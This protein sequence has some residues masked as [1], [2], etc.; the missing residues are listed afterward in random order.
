MKKLVF[1]YLLSIGSVYAGGTI[2]SGDGRLLD[3]EYV[4]VGCP[5]QTQFVCSDVGKC[6]PDA[7]TSSTTFEELLN[8]EPT[9]VAANSCI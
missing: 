1:L 3:C 6:N 7:K 9:A 4:S 5:P 8:S 2:C